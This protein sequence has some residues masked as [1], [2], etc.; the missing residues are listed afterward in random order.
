MRG[1]ASQA[2]IP[3]TSWDAATADADVVVLATTCRREQ[4]PTGQRVWRGQ[5]PC[6]LTITVQ[7]MAAHRYEWWVVIAAAGG[8]KMGAG[9]GAT[10]DE[11]ADEALAQAA[12]AADGVQQLTRR[13]FVS[14]SEAA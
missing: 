14:G 13:A 7:Q 3:D 12:F 5:G 9:R 11:A 2:G 1:Y 8:G 6:G 4:H 10:P